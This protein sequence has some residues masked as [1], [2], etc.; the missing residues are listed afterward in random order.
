MVNSRAIPS[1][2]LCLKSQNN[3]NMKLSRSVYPFN[4]QQTEKQ[5]ISLG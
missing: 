3:Q 4:L 2:D 1:A 5:S